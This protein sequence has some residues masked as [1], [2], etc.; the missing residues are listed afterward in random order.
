[1]VLGVIWHKEL[2]TYVFISLGQFVL[3]FLLTVS[4]VGRLYWLN[5]QIAD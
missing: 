4:D 3:Y 1:M 2:S 5:I